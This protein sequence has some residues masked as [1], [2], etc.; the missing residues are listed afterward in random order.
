M[1]YSFAKKLNR[2]NKRSAKMLLNNIGLKERY[3]KI[4][5]MKYIEGKTAIEISEDLGYARET[6]NNIILKAR[7]ELEEI[8]NDQYDLCDDKLRD[9]I[10]YL[11][12]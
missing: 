4:L 6:I 11:I 12:E 9:I 1:K 10:D 5:W 3:R 7:T 8:I 2:L